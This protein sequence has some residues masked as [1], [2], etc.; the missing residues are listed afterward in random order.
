MHLF[1]VSGLHFGILYIIIK[2]TICLILNNKLFTSFSVIS[3]LFFYLVFIGFAHS[4]QRAFLMIL[5]WEISNLFLREKCAI[6]ALSFSFVIIS[7]IQPESLFVPGFQLSFTIVLLIIWFSRRTII[8]RM[9]KSFLAY[10]F[11]FVKCSLAAFCGSFLILLGSF[12]QIAPISII[13][14][15]ILVPFAFPLI[16]IFIIYIFSFYLLNIDI[17][18]I[19]DIIY[20]IILE[21]L[22]FLNGLPLSYFY[23]NF[24]LNS[25]LYIIL[26]IFVLYLFNKNWNFFKKIIFTLL[27]SFFSV[28]FNY[29]FLSL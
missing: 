27:V 18:F 16:I 13:S 26:P 2:S 15:I 14:N 20:F 5:I 17:Y 10:I 4:A 7:L 12:G 24:K 25:Y 3:I 8:I 6:T 19:V 1:A 9:E 28:F 21:L 22:L 29:L 23:F 11:D